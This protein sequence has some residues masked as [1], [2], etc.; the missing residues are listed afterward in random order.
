MAIT[1]KVLQRPEGGVSYLRAAAKGLAITFSH[2]WKPKVTMQY[3]EQTSADDYQISPRWR[4]TH[5]MLT[6]EQGRPARPR[7]GPTAK[8]ASLMS[9]PTV[10]FA[11]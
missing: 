4:G 5:R 9:D 1:V 11:G 2:L 3:P 7:C 10:P 6:D 8:R